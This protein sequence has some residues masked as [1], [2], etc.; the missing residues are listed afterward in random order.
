[1]SGW[2]GKLENLVE[3]ID[4]FS[5]DFRERLRKNKDDD[6]LLTIIPFIGYGTTKTVLLS[7]RV[8]ENKYDITP[9]KDD[10]RWENLKNLY[11][12]FETDEVSGARVRATFLETTVETE[13]DAEGYFNAA[14]DVNGVLPDELFHEVELHLLAPEENESSA[15]VAAQ[16]LV[17]PAT[18]RFGIISD[19]DDTVLTTNVTN[20][21]KMFLTVA[22]RNEYTRLP[23]RGV[24]A[25]Y[26]ALRKG[27]GG[28]E[29]NPIF[30][31][32]SS[33]WNL[34]ALLTE[35]LRIQEIP[36]GPLFLKDFGSH[37]L[38][39]SSDHQSHKITNIEKILN[40]Y[41]HLP[42]ILIG[43]SGEQ[44]PEIYAEI[45]RRF[46]QRIL[47]IYIRNVNLDPDRVAAIESL[48][49]EIKIAGSQL[50]LAPDTQFAAAHA[51]A[52]NLIAAE[53]LELVEIE[54]LED[55]AAATQQSFA[56]ED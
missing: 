55:D 54:K 43:D 38:F 2:K 10:G 22:L 26:R 42:F 18:A 56:E 44:D 50:V 16:V 27:I 7:G 46:P 13:T 39:S 49:T 24:A 48:I 23:F 37:T 52:Q 25:F 15:R 40:A 28:A 4:N 19:L 6:R 3:N 30:Y 5:D 34:Y 31:V 9:Q 17:P 35:F 41:P 14:L 32:S 21:L 45:V 51:V 36:L 1:M 12:R 11:K 29:N 8:I 33:P 53:E 47:V 20:K